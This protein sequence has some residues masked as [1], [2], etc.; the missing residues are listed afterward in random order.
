MP[1]HEMHEEHHIGDAIAL[2]ALAHLAG[3]KVQTSCFQQDFRRTFG[4]YCLVPVAGAG[5]PPHPVVLPVR[6]L[7]DIL[8][9]LFGERSRCP[10]GERRPLHVAHAHARLGIL[11]HR[12]RHLA[13]FEQVLRLLGDRGLKHEAVPARLLGD[14]GTEQHRPHESARRIA[15]HVQRR[16]HFGVWPSWRELLLVERLRHLHRGDLVQD[17]G[18]AEILRIVVV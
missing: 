1:F 8:V 11:L 15:P 9:P 18:P 5:L 7:G 2:K 12:P 13:G 3:R 14:E 10:L 6:V 4:V 16:G 17:E